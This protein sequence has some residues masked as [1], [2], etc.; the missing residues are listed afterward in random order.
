M[1]KTRILVVD[2]EPYI[3]DILRTTLESE[4][5]ECV[6]A[7]SADEGMRRLST[8]RFDLAFL[9]ILLPGRRGTDLLKDIRQA[10]PDIVVIMITALD[11]ASSAVQAIRLGAYDYIV[12]PFRLDE[13]LVATA[14]AVEKRRL[15]AAAAEYRKHLELAA[16]ERAAETRRLFYS[17]TQVLVRLLELK[18]PVFAGHG[19]RVAEMSRYVAH[20]MKMPEQNVRQ[21]YLAGLLH[22]IGMVAVTDLL[23]NKQA[24]LTADEYRLVRIHPATAEDVLRPILADDEVLKYIRHH[25]ERFDGTGYPDNLKGTDIPLGAR[26][27]AVADAFDSMTQ[28]R[29]YRDAVTPDE[30]LVELDRC[31]D[32]QFDRLVVH[33]FR[34]LYE[35][36]FRNFDKSHMGA[37]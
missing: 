21:V 18:V 33:I 5:Y 15:E 12:K 8:I 7:G 24:A 22:D 1:E 27:I 28:N 9:D 30:A 4:G 13:V 20:E 2:D 10:H 17:M 11:G 25:H 35:Q 36:V 32:T 37:P 29:P 16:E 14:R 3:Q 34:E 26:I 19:A 6:T 23:L 31:S